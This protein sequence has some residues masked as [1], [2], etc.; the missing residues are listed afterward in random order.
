MINY[1]QNMTKWYASK[2]NYLVL[3]GDDFAYM[4]GF[5]AF[6]EVDQLI[7]ICNKYQ[8]RNITF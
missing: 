7:E 1:V 8:Q 6:K 2:E 5:E 4:N 3:L